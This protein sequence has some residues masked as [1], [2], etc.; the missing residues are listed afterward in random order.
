M[1]DTSL[2]D[3]E[4]DNRIRMPNEP[5]WKRFVGCFST[6]VDEETGEEHNLVASDV[7]LRMGDIVLVAGNKW[8]AKLTKWLQS[9]HIFHAEH[10]RWTHV[11]LYIGDGMIVDKHI[12]PFVPWLLRKL[13]KFCGENDFLVRRS[14]IELDDASRVRLL[15]AAIMHLKDRYAYPK[16]IGF[17]FRSIMG[18]LKSRVR[19]WLK[20]RLNYEWPLREQDGW[21]GS[22]E[23]LCT[24][25]VD[26]CH[27]AATR[28]N[29]IP[30]QNVRL[31]E[32]MLTPAAL[33]WTPSLRDVPIRH[34]DIVVPAASPAKG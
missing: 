16:A 23:M 8:N 7:T 2:D 5:P 31:L 24:D 30:M 20:T 9:P 17:G 1:S 6:G 10:R 34:T 22:G 18:G 14:P 26:E 33:S 28:N 11:G 25:L 13:D 19:H 21:I 3:E 29:L 27:R 12:N 32:Y 4:D 15:H